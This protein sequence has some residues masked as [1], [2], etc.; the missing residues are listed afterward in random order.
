M[1]RK[2]A[3]RVARKRLKSAAKHLKAGDANRFYEEIYRAIW[4]CL[5]DKY[6]IEPSRLSR[7]TVRQCLDDKQVPADRQESILKV[8]QDVDMARFAPGDAHAQM[9]TVYDEAL[10]MI[11]GLE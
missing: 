8:L 5:S 7:D 10:D 4:G 11:V 3:L 6:S 2:R 9:Q 1:R